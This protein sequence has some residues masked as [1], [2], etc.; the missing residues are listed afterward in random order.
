MTFVLLA[1]GGFLALRAWRM[2]RREPESEPRIE[3][4]AGIGGGLVC[5]IAVGL[6][7][8]FMSESI[9]LSQEHASW[10]A[11]VESAASVP[12]F[13]AAGHDDVKTINF[14]GKS[15]HDANF[16]HADLRGAQF[17]DADLTGAT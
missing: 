12:G 8:L 13:A 16:N 5:G 15:L 14:S 6:S 1:L 9:R 11:G 2:A 10:R 7:A 4:L 3:V 17:R